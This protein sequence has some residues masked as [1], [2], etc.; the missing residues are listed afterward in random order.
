MRIDPLQVEYLLLSR[1]AAALAESSI[2]QT[3]ESIASVSTAFDV[4]PR[5]HS[6][7]L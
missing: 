4:L 1:H 7:R 5:F 6:A 2:R 3:G